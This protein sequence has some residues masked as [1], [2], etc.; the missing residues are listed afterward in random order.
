MKDR[1]QPEQHWH[2]IEGAFWLEVGQWQYVMYS[3]ACFENETYH[4]GYASASN[5]EKD[6]M[7]VNFVK[8]TEQGKLA[9]LM[10]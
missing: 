7:K 6:L 4:I 10:T 1:Y 3:G 9:P 2:T 5:K 8:R